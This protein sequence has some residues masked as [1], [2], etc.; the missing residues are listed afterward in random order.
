MTPYKNSFNTCMYSGRYVLIKRV[1]FFT[2]IY[3]ISWHVPL[4][5]VGS[6]T[7]S[8]FSF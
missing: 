4:L 5:D 8:A 6:I 2:K 7:G 1:Y 3:I